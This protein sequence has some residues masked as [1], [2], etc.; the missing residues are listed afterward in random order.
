MAIFAR[1]DSFPL[2]PSPCNGA[3]RFSL[4]QTGANV[5]LENFRTTTVQHAQYRTRAFLI[6]VALELHDFHLSPSPET[7]YDRE[8]WHSPTPS[9]R[10][11]KFVPTPRFQTLPPPDFSW[12]I[13]A[14]I[15]LAFTATLAAL[16]TEAGSPVAGEAVA[17][18]CKT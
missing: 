4:R 10:S 14:L 2:R 17:K 18:P 5:K 3:R 13:P 7:I 12:T 8:I 9:P 6:P 11:P 15:R 16:A 1:V